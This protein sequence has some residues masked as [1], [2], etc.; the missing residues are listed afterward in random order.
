VGIASLERISHASDDKDTVF[1]AT[2]DTFPLVLPDGK[3]VAATTEG[4]TVKTTKKRAPK[5]GSVAGLALTLEE[6]ELLGRKVGLL[7]SSGIPMDVIADVLGIDEPTA[8]KILGVSITEKSGCRDVVFEETFL[9]FIKDPGR[10]ELNVEV[11]SEVPKQKQQPCPL[12]SVKIKLVEALQSQDLFLDLRRTP[13]EG[14]TAGRID[15][16]CQLWPVVRSGVPVRTLIDRATASERRAL[17]AQG[18]GVKMAVWVYLARDLRNTDLFGGKSDPY[19]VGQL[20]DVSKVKEVFKT[21]VIDDEPNPEWNF[22]PETV[23]WNGEA[24]FRFEVFDKDLLRKGDKLGEAVLSREQCLRGLYT[25]LDLGEGN[26]TLRVKV[27]PVVGSEP[28]TVA[29][30]AP[31]AKPKV[32]VW[33]MSAQDLRAVNLFGGSSDP[34][35]VCSLSASKRFETHVI[36]DCLKPLWDFGPKELTLGTETELKFEVRDKDMIGSS[37]LGTATLKREQCL[38]GFEGVLRLGKGNGTLHVKVQPLRP[39]PELAPITFSVSVLSAKDLRNTDL[40]GKSDPYVKCKLGDRELFQ[41]KVVWNE[42]NPTW[43]HGPEVVRLEQERELTFEV[44]DKDLFQQGDL[45]GRAVLERQRCAAGFYGDL[46]LGPGNGTLRV[47]V[48]TLMGEQIPKAE[49]KQELSWLAALSQ[50]L[51]CGE[52]GQKVEVPVRGEP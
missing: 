52:V 49:H 33:I 4:V 51:P 13:L 37:T 38:A 22:G 12:G 34:Y 23:E 27:A 15:I 1:Y 28:A 16:Q 3:E 20:I 29:W 50:C 5:D 32:Q 7:L 40:I 10:A 26:G 39:G 25:D 47:H 43:D 42:P 6:S 30:T 14:A 36:N 2:V 24:S 45:L 8:R 19:C 41:T 9:Y 17:A 31:K 18:R 11:Y 21:Q 44:Y 46:D 35:V 48:L